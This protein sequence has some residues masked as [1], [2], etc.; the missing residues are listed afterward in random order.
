MLGANQDAQVLNRGRRRNSEYDR[1]HVPNPV[2][3]KDICFVIKQIYAI[4]SGKLL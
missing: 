4:L 3:E 2:T 1:K